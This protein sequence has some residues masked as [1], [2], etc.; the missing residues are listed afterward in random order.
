MSV[1]RYFIPLPDITA[2]ELAV[3]AANA[4]QGLG[5]CLANDGVNFEDDQWESLPPG[6]KRHFNIA[7]QRHLDGP[8]AFIVDPQRIVVVNDDPAEPR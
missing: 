5:A 8:Q 1:K 3:I 6:I 2:Y 7:S 4:A